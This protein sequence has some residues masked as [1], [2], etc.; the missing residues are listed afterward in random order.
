MD[1]YLKKY[2]TNSFIMSLILIVFS[3]ILIIKPIAILN[4]V[5]IIVG[6]IIFLDGI[7]HFISYAKKP[8]QFKTLNVELAQG[9]IES[10]VGAI[11]IFHPTWLVS[12]FPF[13]IGAWIIYESVIKIQLAITYRESSNNK[14]IIM[15]VLSILTIILGLY[16]MINPIESV[17]T[18]IRICSIGLLISEI[19]NAIE[20]SY[21][22]IKLD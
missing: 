11:L 6:I 19:L 15:L 2:G 5:M 14:W 3:I 16:L 9:I 17:A 1:G 10:L 7:M 18:V 12:I 21:M 20:C 4:T 13:L 22:M 8:D